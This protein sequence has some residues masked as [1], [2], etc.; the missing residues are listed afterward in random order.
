LYHI[1]FF[2]TILP[3]RKEKRNRLLETDLNDE[4]RAIIAEGDRE[5]EEHPENFVLLEHISRA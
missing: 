1:L 3:E 2:L 4:E 5:F